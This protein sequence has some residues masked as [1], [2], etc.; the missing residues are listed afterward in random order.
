MDDALLVRGF[1]RFC[2]LL[3]NRQHLVDRN[4]TS[5]NAI[6]QRFALDELHDE[7][8]LTV[9]FLDAVDACNIGMA[10]RR[11]DFGFTLKS[12]ETIKISSE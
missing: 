12:C 7:R 5:R 1:E 11:E 8:A 2:D 9:R 10:E 3:G 6:G 4:C